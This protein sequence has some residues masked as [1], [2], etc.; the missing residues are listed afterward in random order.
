MESLNKLLKLTY[1][2]KCQNNP[3]TPIPT[4]TPTPTHP[5]NTVEQHELNI[6]NALNVNNNFYLYLLKTK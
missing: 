4:P 2:S 5:Q 3:P 1:F 6:L